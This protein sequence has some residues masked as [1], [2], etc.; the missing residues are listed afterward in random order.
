MPAH[1]CDGIGSAIAPYQQLSV[2]Q[3]LQGFVD[4]RLVALVLYPDGIKKAHRTLHQL[5]RSF[6]EQYRLPACMPEHYR[7][8]MTKTVVIEPS[9][10]RCGSPAGVDRV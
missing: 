9:E 10:Q 4:V 8:S 7:I 2:G 3:L 1:Y 6:R 5:R